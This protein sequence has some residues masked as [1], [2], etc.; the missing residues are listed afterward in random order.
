MKES[1]ISRVPTE[2]WEGILE[3]MLDVGVFFDTVC[4]VQSKASIL[5][6]AG[7]EIHFAKPT[8]RVGK[9]PWD[10]QQ[11][12]SLMVRMGRVSRPYVPGRSENIELSTRWTGLCSTYELLSLATKPLEDQHH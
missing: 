9:A 3:Q 2:I 12:V 5:Q 1:A 11:S 4:T 6:N 8:A 7:L 10:Y